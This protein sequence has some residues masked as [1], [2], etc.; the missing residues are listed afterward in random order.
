MRTVDPSIQCHVIVNTEH[1]SI[2]SLS[3]S[4]DDEAII[5][6]I[7]DHSLNLFILSING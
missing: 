2:D 6:S 4:S 5:G 3:Q 1:A 7:I